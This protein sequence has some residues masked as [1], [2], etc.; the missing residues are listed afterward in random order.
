MICDSCWGYDVVLHPCLCE[1]PR[2]GGREE[3][4]APLLPDP[5]GWLWTWL[6]GLPAPACGSD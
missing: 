1:E 3:A 6:R 4:E 5:V 2:P